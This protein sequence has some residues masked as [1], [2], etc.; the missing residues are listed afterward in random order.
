MEPYDDD[1]FMRLSMRLHDTV[2]EIMEME[3]NDEHLVRE[4]VDNAIEN[5][6]EA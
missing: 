3:G 1:K 2:A 6:K 5:A 4:E